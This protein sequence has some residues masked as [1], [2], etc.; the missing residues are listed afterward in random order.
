MDT[1]GPEGPNKTLL[2]ELARPEWSLV[3]RAVGR[4]EK[5]LLDAGPGAP[6]SEEAV[7]ALVGLSR[8]PKW[9]VRRAI[10]QTAGQVQHPAFESTVARLAI[11]DNS[12]VKQAA[13]QAAGRRRDWRNTSL[14]GRQHEDR[15]NS[16]LDDIEARF[17]PRSRDA[18]RRA[19]EEI[20]NIYARELYHEVVKL[21]TPLVMSAD[22]LGARVS[23]ES[24]PRAELL[25]DVAKVRERVGRIGTTL[26]AM[27]S[28]T[29]VPAIKYAHEPLKDVVDEAASL[30]RD[31]D[32]SKG[33]HVGIDVRVPPSLTVEADRGRLVQAFTNLLHNASEAYSGLEGRGPVVVTAVEEGTRV[34]LVFQDEG[35]GMSEEAQKDALLLF[36][37]SKRHGTGFGLPLAIKI[38]EAE[39]LGQLVLTSEMGVGTRVEIRLPRFRR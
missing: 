24:V 16:R 13:D 27:R 11:D 38:L 10:A 8:H 22:R 3:L 34:T 7:A 30:V 23:D 12:R 1:D 2:N 20:A 32:R 18:V 17:G 33:V 29:A 39:H 26:G 31:S 5:W 14:L 35:C 21:L 4:A 15:I 19:S 28:Y 25:H 9:E 37:T 6:G 36:S